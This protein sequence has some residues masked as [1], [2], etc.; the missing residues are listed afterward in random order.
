[1][2]GVESQDSPLS[3]SELLAF[4]GEAE[5]GTTPVFS[6]VVL[7]KVGRNSESLQCRCDGPWP[8]PTDWGS[9]Q[10]YRF[11]ANRIVAAF[12]GTPNLLD[13]QVEGCARIDHQRVWRDVVGQG[14]RGPCEAA[15]E[16]RLGQSV[17]V[18][19]RPEDARIASASSGAGEQELT[20]S[21]RI[22]QTTFR[23]ATRSIVVQTDNGQLN[24]DASALQ[25]FAIGDD[26]SV[27]VP[28]RAAWA[29]PREEAIR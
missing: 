19:V 3:R 27:V 14:W 6:N 7:E 8:Y 17:T 18:M 29:L 21:G 9:E 5:T 23:G 15:H 13:A 28:Q 16:M 20:W 25:H 1:M 4:R 22:K 2:G 26:V 24:V 10:I 12:F 11:P